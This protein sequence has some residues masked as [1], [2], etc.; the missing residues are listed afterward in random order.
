MTEPPLIVRLTRPRFLAVAGSCFVVVWIVAFIGHELAT[1]GLVNHQ[2]N[3]VGR[4]FLGFYAAGKIVRSGDGRALYDPAR[5]VQ[6]QAQILAP[7]VQ[8]GHIYFINPAFWAVAFVPLTAL[9]YRAAVYVH[10][11]TMGAAFVIGMWMLRRQLSGI[12]RGWRAA[13]L[14]GLVWFPMIHTVLGGQN[15]A[16]TFMLFCAA[17]VAT[18]TRR[19]PFAGL[20]LGIQLYKPQFALPLLGLVLLRGEL[21]TVG[22]AVVVAVAEYA[23]GAAC[24]GAGWPLRMIASARGYYRDAESVANGYK[25]IAVPEVLDYSVGYPLA[26]TGRRW[27]L[28][29]TRAVGLSALLGI[30]GYL[31]WRWRRV[32]ARQDDFGLYWALAVALSTVA[33]LHANDYE[34]ALLVLPVL[35]IIDH[36]IRGG[37][38]VKP[39]ERCTLAALYLLA[40]SV[41]LLGVAQR[42]QFQPFVLLPLGV[43]WWAARE[44]RRPDPGAA[45]R[46]AKREGG[47]PSEGQNPTARLT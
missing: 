27:A 1:P 23:I 30:F 15:T 43:A 33:S 44:L 46:A 39:A 31:A 34:T 19:Q 28:P 29:L 8:R 21:V 13:T 6:T 47:H 18:A 7:D 14:V 42:L 10:V 12:R 4:D 3:A 20:A 24:C 11:L 2:G 25:H 9:P 22:V 5:Q 36:R 38:L 45:S 26:R 32:D 17:F 37:D 40:P 35:L 16:L 41:A